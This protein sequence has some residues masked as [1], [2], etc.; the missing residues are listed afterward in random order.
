MF[1]VR[2]T[3]ALGFFQTNHGNLLEHVSDFA[4]SHP[5]LDLEA[6]F[7]KATPTIV[8]TLTRHGPGCLIVIS[9]II[10]AVLQ[11]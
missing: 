4:A 6:R 8:L 5:R 2:K 3:L 1:E 7:S 9:T 11:L 10:F